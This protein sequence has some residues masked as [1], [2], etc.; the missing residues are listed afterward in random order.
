MRVDDSCPWDT[1][2]AAVKPFNTSKKLSYAY[3][4]IRRFNENYL[5]IS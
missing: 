1:E 5:R 4:S 3:Q 2:F